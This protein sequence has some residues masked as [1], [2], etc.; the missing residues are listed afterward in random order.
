M[1]IFL[2]G[3]SSA[4]KTSIAHQLQA[5]SDKPI[6]NLGYD[7][8]VVTLPSS[9]LGDG[10]A[11]NLGFQYIH[12]IDNDKPKTIIK[13][14]PIGKQLS[15]A[16]H[17]SMKHLADSQFNLIIDEVLFDDDAFQD[18]LKVFQTQCVYLFSIKP[19]VDVA[20][21][22]EKKRGDRA[23]GLARGLYDLVYPNRFCDLELDSSLITP[24][25]AAKTILDFIEDCPNP[26]A[27]KSHK[28][29]DSKT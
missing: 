1:I 25:E 28:R 21:M 4:G 6:L 18:Y 8:F 5:Q 14:G 2:N 15:Y 29:A 16:M 19:P 9:Y 17:R 26:Q 7:H 20:V 22:R 10:S 23:I 24:S 11:A 13:Y 3:T 12:S 27:F